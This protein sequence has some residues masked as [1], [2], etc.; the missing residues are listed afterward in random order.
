M[1]IDINTSNPGWKKMGWYLAFSTMLLL[2]VCSA[3]GATTKNATAKFKPMA[4]KLMAAWASLDVNKAAPF[5]AKDAGLAFYDAAPLKYTGWN[6]YAEGSKKMF[7][8]WKSIEMSVGPDFQAFKR[9]DTAWWTFTSHVKITLNS[10]GEI[11]MD[12]RLTDILEKRGSDWLVVHEHFSTPMTK[13]PPPAANA[14]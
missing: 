13:T 3:E 4:E 10:G 6:E 7:D 2:A 1:D 11:S 9:R 12:V 8:E 5:Y 14:K